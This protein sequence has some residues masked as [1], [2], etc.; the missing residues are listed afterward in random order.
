MTKKDFKVG[1][2]VYLLGYDKQEDEFCVVESG[3]RLGSILNDG[4]CRIEHH[5]DYTFVNARLVF[6]NKEEAQAECAK[7]NKFIKD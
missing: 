3:W 4:S 1:D 2:V 6:T 7:R 5:I